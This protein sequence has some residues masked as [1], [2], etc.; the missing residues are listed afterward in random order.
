ME[1]EVENSGSSPRTHSKRPTPSA[2]ASLPAF[3]P[4]LAVR[5]QPSPA[6]LLRLR[7]SVRP[8]P[9]TPTAQAEGPVAS[10]AQGVPGTWLGGSQTPEPFPLGGGPFPATP[11]SSRSSFPCHFVP[12]LALTSHPAARARKVPA[13]ERTAAPADQRRPG[14]VSRSAVGAHMWGRSPH[15]NGGSGR[16]ERGSG[17]DLWRGFVSVPRLRATSAV[18]SR[19]RMSL[20]LAVRCLLRACLRG[21]LK[22]GA[23]P[24]SPSGVGGCGASGAIDRHA[25]RSGLGKG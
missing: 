20:S 14:A 2:P 18:P 17:V 12:S 15:R 9:G 6:A 24:P 13:L 1:E 16:R 22:V 19:A 8:R 7:S 10:G 5:A 4:A 11:C 23:R 3:H 25:R 21:G